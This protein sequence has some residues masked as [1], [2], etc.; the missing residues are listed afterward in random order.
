[1]MDLCISLAEISTVTE[2]KSVSL[3]IDVQKGDTVCV[4]QYISETASLNLVTR[5]CS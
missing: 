5:L 4:W 3:K 1:M 2:E